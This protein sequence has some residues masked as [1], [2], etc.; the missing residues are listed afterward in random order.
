MKKNV[1]RGWKQIEDAANDAKTRKL[2]EE[3]WREYK[4]LSEEESELD[5]AMNDPMFVDP[6]RVLMTVEMMT[7]LI[8]LI[9]RSGGVEGGGEKRGCIV[10]FLPFWAVFSSDDVG[11]FLS[12]GCRGSALVEKIFR[13]HWFIL[14]EK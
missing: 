2:L 9:V 14:E 8:S 6:Y 5:E 7:M 11:C 3:S 13:G 12:F 4:G 10:A 1:L